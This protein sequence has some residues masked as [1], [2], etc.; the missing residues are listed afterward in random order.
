MTLG[1]SQYRAYGCVTVACW[2]IAV[3]CFSVSAWAETPVPERPEAAAAANPAASLGEGATIST[4]NLLKL[5]RNGGPLMIPIA[6]CS[7]VLVVFVFERA[8]SLRQGRVV[9][10]PFV[11]RFVNQLEEGLLDREDAERLCEENRSPVSEVFA[12]AVHK[13]G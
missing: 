2:C 13:W 10:R 3:A 11:K 1:I 7:F 4:T 5:I 9:P 6:I 8:I 12:A